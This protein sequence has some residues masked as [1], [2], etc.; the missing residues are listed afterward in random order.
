MCNIIQTLHAQVS[1]KVSAELEK[2]KEGRVKK[3][4]ARSIAVLIQEGVLTRQEAEAEAR[5]YGV[6]SGDISY[7]APS[8]GYGSSCYSTQASS[9]NRC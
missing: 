2:E 1:R 8:E 4:L 7:N 5:R 6:T 9:G 3:Q